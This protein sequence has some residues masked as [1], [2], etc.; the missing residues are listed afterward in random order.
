MV[1]IFYCQKAYLSSTK[2][3]NIFNARAFTVNICN[4]Q[5]SIAYVSQAKRIIIMVWIMIILCN[6][7]PL[8]H[9][10]MVL[11]IIV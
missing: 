11:Y 1:R 4:K 9:C 5:I 7:I 8:V 2:R 6:L 3:V 10:V